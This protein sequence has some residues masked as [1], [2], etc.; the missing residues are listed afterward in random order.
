MSQFNT[1]QVFTIDDNFAVLVS[2]S[3]FL[4]YEYEALN[5]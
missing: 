4:R 2:S 3:V 1:S 5:K